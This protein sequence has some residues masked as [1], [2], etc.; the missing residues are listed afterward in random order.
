MTPAPAVPFVE[1]GAVTERLSASQVGRHM[2]CHASA[3]LE[4]AIPG[5]EKPV[6]DRT[7]DTAANRGNDIHED[8]ARVMKHPARDVKAIA[9]ALAYVAEVQGRR[10]FKVL[11]EQ[12]IKATWLKGEPETT[13]DLVLYVEDEIHVIDWKTG[14]I[15]VEAINNTQLWYY[16]ASF[17]P[18]APRAKG[19]T[20][21]IVQPWAD[22]IDWQWVPT[23]DL[24]VF[25]AQVQQTEDAILGGDL[26]FGPSDHCMFC[27]ANPHGRGLRGS[28]N[29][30]AMMQI[31]YPSVVDEAEILGL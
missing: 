29:C 5:Y 31:L 22:N 24:S 18:L 26:S 16:A 3:N 27:A 20:V 14:R 7:A 10:R 28:Q 6:E 25:M 9:E 4:L 23:T 12:S 15:K 11:V 2:A 19:V 13:V 21:H 17:A 30:P 8:L 1:G